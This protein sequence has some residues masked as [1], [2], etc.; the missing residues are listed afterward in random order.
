MGVEGLVLVGFIR[1]VN[2][3]EEEVEVP[4]DFLSIR[5]KVGEMERDSDESP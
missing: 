3:C 2:G 4:F 1:V 5:V